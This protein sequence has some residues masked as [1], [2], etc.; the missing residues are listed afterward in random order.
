MICDKILSGIDIRPVI[1]GINEGRRGYP[2]M[3]FFSSGL[4]EKYNYSLAGGASDDCAV[5]QHNAFTFTAEDTGL[6]LILT[7]SSREL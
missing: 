3:N 2:H 1:A 6:N 7:L 4:S 5:N